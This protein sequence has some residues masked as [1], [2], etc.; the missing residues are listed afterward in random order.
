[1]H[2]SSKGR[3]ALRAMVDLALH[4]DRPVTRQEIAARQDIS[5]N[6]LA[7]I[8]RPLQRAELV[9]AIRGPGG[10]Y[11]LARDAA[12][13]RVG[14]VLRAAEGPL[15]LSEC[16]SPGKLPCPRAPGCRVRPL[17]ACLTAA[18]TNVLDSTSLADLCNSEQIEMRA[19]MRFK[20][21]RT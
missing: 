6:Y 21:H 13:I 18:I 20:K 8:F 11:V 7:Q 3:Y 9:K 4:A 12:T 16:V 2:V 15:T 14:E 5:V 1:M 17:W 10:G 19:E